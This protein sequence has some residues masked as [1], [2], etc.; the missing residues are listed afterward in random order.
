V[1]FEVVCFSLDGIRTLKN[2]INKIRKIPLFSEINC[3]TIVSP[4]YSVVQYGKSRKKIVQ[5]VAKFLNLISKKILSKKG[6]FRI[7]NITFN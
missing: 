3:K 6:I 7:V 2:S 5:I 1:D 4:R